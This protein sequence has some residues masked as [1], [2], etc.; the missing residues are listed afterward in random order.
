MTA[1]RA[2][3]VHQALALLHAPAS[4]A[5]VRAR[6]LPEEMTRLLRIVSGDG[7]IT[8]LATQET[9]Q[10]AEVLQEASEFFVLQVCFTP[11][12]DSYRVLGVDPLASTPRIREHYRLLVRWLHPDRNPDA[13]QSGFLDRVNQAWRDLR[14]TESRARYDQHR[15]MEALG[16]MPATAPV[17]TGSGAPNWGV[18]ASGSRLSARTMRWLPGVVLTLMGMVATLVL[19]LM[20]IDH[21]EDQRAALALETLN[22][23]ARQSQSTQPTARRDRD[24]SSSA[25]AATDVPVLLATAAPPSLPMET[26]E[27]QPDVA[28]AATPDPPAPKTATDTRSKPV[29]S[30]AVVD[31]PEAGVVPVAK[32]QA[33][34]VGAPPAAT[35]Q[36][37][38][39]AV[40]DVARI[41]DTP[42]EAVDAQPESVFDNVE[43]TPLLANA[44]AD[45]P[46]AAATNSI[47]EP[48]VNALLQSYR[49]AYDAG[50]LVRLMALFTRDARNLPEGSHYL[51]ETYRQLFETS[52][53]RRLSLK[54]MSWWQEGDAVAVVASFDA[55][56]TPVGRERPRRFGGDIRFDLRREDGEVRIQRVRHQT[57]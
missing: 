28:S 39:M 42:K 17:M 12:I 35:P 30:A 56:I 10:P 2:T 1:A 5:E 37:T 45:Q 50:D 22:D 49:D 52:R 33:S 41:V 25:A 6:A 23:E 46:A 27:A 54:N 9:H 19:V 44:A 3:A 26:T 18:S 57:Q 47:E 7:S 55:A 11:G 4:V 20:Y 48:V 31:K 16:E 34:S 8:L 24:R 14:D 38:E 53:S 29:A 13:W 21:V 51:V 40:A 36:A 32:V 15:A 43:S